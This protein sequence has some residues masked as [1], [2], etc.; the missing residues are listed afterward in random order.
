MPTLT[1]DEMETHF[2]I[3]AS[4]R[5]IVEIYSDDPVYQRK[6]EAV[7]AFLVRE[8]PDRCGKHYTLPA[9]QLSLRRPMTKQ[10]F[11]AEQKAAQVLRG[12]K[13]AQARAASR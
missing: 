10:S 6:L 3:V 4:D 11:T 12:Q 8:E 5:S 2:N 7:G 1:L 9:K 13:L